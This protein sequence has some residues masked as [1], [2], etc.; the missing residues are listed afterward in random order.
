MD[1]A[2]KST[3]SDKNCSTDFECTV[4]YLGKLNA[5]Y[6]K[7]GTLEN[8]ARLYQKACGFLGR[9]TEH[10]Q[11]CVSRHGIILHG[12]ENQ[13]EFKLDRISFCASYK[14]IPKVVAFNY[15][16]STTGPRRMECHA[17]LCR[18][19]EE[20]QDVVRAVTAAFRNEFKAGHR[21]KQSDY[22]TKIIGDSNNNVGT[23]TEG[24]SIPRKIGAIFDSLTKCM[25]DIQT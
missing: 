12:K 14:K 24:R 1:P 21:I 7:I 6:P 22:Y 2:T 4:T 3:Q 18:S 23:E 17:V 10:S 5:I 25:S 20:T 16:T 19:L 8:A 15:L 11:L 13:T 9:D